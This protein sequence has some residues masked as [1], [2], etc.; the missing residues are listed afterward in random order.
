MPTRA[1]QPCILFVGEKFESVPALKMARS[2]VLDM[3][4]GEQVC[5]AC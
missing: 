4:R 1:L 5:N 2:L 3:F